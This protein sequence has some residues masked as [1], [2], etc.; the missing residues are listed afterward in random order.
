MIAIAFGLL[1]AFYMFGGYALTR[2]IAMDGLIDTVIER[3]NLPG[4]A[5]ETVDSEGFKKQFLGAMAVVSFAG[6][7]FLFFQSALATAL[8]CICLAMQLLHILVLGPRFFDRDEDDD[9]IGSGRQATINAMIVYAVV[10]FCLLYAQH[11]GALPSFPPSWSQRESAGLA[12]SVAFAIY[13]YRLMRAPHTDHAP[14]PDLTQPLQ[15]ND[16]F[17][18]AELRVQATADEEGLWV[19]SK[20][21]DV[22]ET[23]EPDLLGISIALEL[24]ISKWED[25][26]D[27]FCDTDEMDALNDEPNWNDPEKRTH[28]HEAHSI[29]QLVKDEVNSLQPHK[30]KVTWVNQDGEILD[31]QA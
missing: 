17:K 22:W 29:A 21:S 10:T 6:G 13:A 25:R 11:L 5:S 19:R 20:A 16:T 27:R 7:A 24:R 30:V 26:Y 3:I 18:I 12:L 2:A 31:I 15:P 1:G 9:T 23:V 28:F 8:F 4:E 14:D